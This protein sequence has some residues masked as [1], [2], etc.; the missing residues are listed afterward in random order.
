MIDSYEIPACEL[1]IEEEIKHSRFISF[2]FQCDSELALKCALTDIKARYPGASHYCY[3]YIGADPGNDSLMGSSDDGE[4]AG[5]AGR[6]MLASL[7][8]A[9]LGEVAAVVVRYYGGTKLG[10]G[11]L[12]RAYTSGLKQGLS[13]L[14][15]QL[16]QVRHPGSLNCNYAQLR[17]IEH[18]LAQ[19]DALIEARAFEACIT[20]RFQLAK[21]HRQAV[22]AA[23]ATLTQ[24]ECRANFDTRD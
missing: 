5:S 7:Q 13:R 12:V 14:D 11:G 21:G 20:L 9:N 15:R 24:G 23:L 19:Y 22:N 18:L 3:A 4:P 6:P 1:V 16:K 10:V 17:D 8:G 2:L